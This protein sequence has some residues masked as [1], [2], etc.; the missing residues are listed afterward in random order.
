MR[1]FQ[2]FK[3]FIRILF[4]VV[5]KNVVVCIE[6][7]MVTNIFLSAMMMLLFLTNVFIPEGE[8]IKFESKK[9]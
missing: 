8:Q 1:N 3:V 2:K 7:L 6:V 4:F 9:T 5:H